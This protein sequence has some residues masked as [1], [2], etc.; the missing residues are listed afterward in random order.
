MAEVITEDQPRIKF[1]CELC[2]SDEAAPL[3]DADED[4][5][6]QV[7][8][9][10]AR[11]EA[12]GLTPLLNDGLVAGNCAALAESRLFVTVSGKRAGQAAEFVEVT[13]FDKAAWR[14]RY[15]RRRREDQSSRPSSDTP[16]LASL[17]LGEAPLAPGARIVLHGHA[18]AGVGGEDGDGGLDAARALG[19]AISDKETLFSTP[20]DLAEVEKLLERHPYV[21]GGGFQLYVR[22]GH[23]FFLLGQNADEVAAALGRVVLAVE[24]AR[25][26]A[27]EE[28]RVSL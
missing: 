9:L 12:Q 8:S 27:A 4:L 20:E 2:D 7:S 22:R 25:T 28:G 13:G 24:E 14:C 19:A 23:G 3:S 16:L 5:L 1:Q 17:L 6:R 18:L 11:A 26:A 21:P 10:L 15:R